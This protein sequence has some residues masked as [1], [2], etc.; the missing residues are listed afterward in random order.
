MVIVLLICTAMKCRDMLF[1][2]LCNDSCADY[3]AKIYECINCG[4]NLP[5]VFRT[6][7]ETL[8]CFPASRSSL[9]S[10]LIIIKVTRIIGQNIRFDTFHFWDPRHVTQLSPCLHVFDVIFWLLF[11]FNF[12]WMWC[13]YFKRK[14]INLK[15]DPSERVKD[16]P[17]TQ[18]SKYCIKAMYNVTETNEHSSLLTIAS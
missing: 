2:R 17:G 7:D 1:S 12:R 5:R 8:N 18:T 9:L 4:R 16:W 3:V 13:W 10:L 6:R 14:M 11:V 15:L